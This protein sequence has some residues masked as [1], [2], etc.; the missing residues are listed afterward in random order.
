MDYYS[1][2]KRNELLMH[3]AIWMALK[4]IMVKEKSQSYI[5]YDS[6]YITFSKWQN[7]RD[8]EQ[9]SGCWKGACGYKAVAW[10][11]LR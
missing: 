3:A 2:V 4:G 10:G 5:L 9:I 6:I 8:A 1:I 7:Y 11:A